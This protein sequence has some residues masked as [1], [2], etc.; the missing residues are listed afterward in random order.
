MKQASDV[1]VG[2]VITTQN[3]MD[4]DYRAL[5]TAER[6]WILRLLTD[7]DPA[8]VMDGLSGA[9]NN[10]YALFELEHI[11]T[12]LAPRTCIPVHYPMKVFLKTRYP[13]KARSQNLVQIP[14]PKRLQ[15][16]QNSDPSPIPRR[17]IFHLVAKR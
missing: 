3:P 11:V 4:L 13:V 16:S 15:C 7:A 14:K 1:G 8:K 10:P 17:L 6:W 9:T 12:R 5:P 2:V